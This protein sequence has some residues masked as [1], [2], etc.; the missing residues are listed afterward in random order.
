MNALAEGLAR[1]QSEAGGMMELVIVRPTDAVDIMADALA[2]DGRAVSLLQAM[3][4]AAGA[5]RNAPRRLPMLCAA[6]PR[7]LRHGRYAF[8]VAL[9]ARDNPTHGLTLAVCTRCAT[10]RGDIE[11]KATAA[12]RRVFP[13]LRPV[14][15]THA[16]GGRA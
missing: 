2:G 15:V 9:P 16:T 5:I 13:D 11:A 6:C 8:G 3:E 7:P 4:Q 10:A 14:T 1:L 12:L